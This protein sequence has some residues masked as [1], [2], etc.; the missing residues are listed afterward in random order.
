MVLRVDGG[1]EP[2]IDEYPSHIKNIANKNPPETLTQKLKIHWNISWSR[3]LKYEMST[4][5]IISQS[6][7][8]NLINIVMSM[9]QIFQDI[10][11]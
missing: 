8:V 6:F 9:E 2:N 4:K 10:S 3:L 11:K 1:Q 7:S 5:L